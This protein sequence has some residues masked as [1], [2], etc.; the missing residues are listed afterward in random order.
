MTMM[1]WILYRARYSFGELRRRDGEMCRPVPACYIHVLVEENTE[2]HGQATSRAP[3][4]AI[5]QQLNL[6]RHLGKNSNS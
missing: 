5:S 4:L 2:L 1:G 3:D 6:A